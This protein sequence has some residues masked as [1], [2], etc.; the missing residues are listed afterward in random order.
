MSLYGRVQPAR[1]M[2]AHVAITWASCS[3]VPRAWE[4]VIVDIQIIASVASAE[5]VSGVNNADWHHCGHSSLEY[6]G[7]HP[8]GYA[9][10]RCRSCGDRLVQRELNPEQRKRVRDMV[11]GLDQA[12][13]ALQQEPLEKIVLD[14]AASPVIRSDC[15][16]FDYCAVC[17]S[18]QT[19]AGLLQ[20]EYDCA[21]LAALAYRQELSEKLD[22]QKLP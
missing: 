21:Y 20:H 6:V 16:G 4:M 19:Y 13:M 8:K 15:D 5:E 7:Q 11:T 22:R 2:D 1:E 17:G 9:L 18:A 12:M 3:R 10:F 14:L